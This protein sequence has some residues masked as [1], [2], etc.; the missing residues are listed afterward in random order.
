MENYPNLGTI[1]DLEILLF[2]LE[3]SAMLPYLYVSYN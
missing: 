1:V 3:A 2:D